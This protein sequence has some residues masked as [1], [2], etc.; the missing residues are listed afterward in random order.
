MHFSIKIKII[1]K[2]EPH[3]A[4]TLEK[5]EQIKLLFYLAALPKVTG[6]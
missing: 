2:P 3:I 6:I 1:E 4:F 5:G